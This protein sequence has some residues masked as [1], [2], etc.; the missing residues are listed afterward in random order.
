MKR[1]NEAK[2]RRLVKES[3]MDEMAT[4]WKERGLAGPYKLK[5]GEMGDTLAALQ[6]YVTPEGELP[7][8]FIHFGGITEQDVTA[9]KKTFKGAVNTYI[10]KKVG[11]ARSVTAPNRQSKHGPQF[12]FGVNPRSAEKYNTPYGIYAYPLTPSIFR[13]LSDGTLPFAQNE[14]FILLFKT[15]DRVPLIYTSEDIPED[16]Y[17]EYVQRLFSDEMVESER[18]V[19][20]T[21]GH[22]WEKKRRQHFGDLGGADPRPYDPP[23]DFLLKGKRELQAAYE[24]EEDPYPADLAFVRQSEHDTNQYLTDAMRE[25]LPFSASDSHSAH[26][27]GLVRSAAQEDPVRWSAMM[28]KLGIGGIVDDAGTGHIHSQEPVQ[29]VFFT[30]RDPEKNLEL[31]GVFPNTHTKRKIERRSLVEKTREIRE[32]VKMLVKEIHP[33]PRQRVDRE[34]I[35]NLISFIGLRD[36]SWIL[37]PHVDT[38]DMRE[39]LIDLREEGGPIIVE[40]YVQNYTGGSKIELTNSWVEWGRRMYD[41]G[42]GSDAIDSHPG[43][44]EH[45]AMVHKLR[46]LDNFSLSSADEKRAQEDFAYA[47]N[48]LAKKFKEI[49]DVV[50]KHQEMLDNYLQEA[51]SQVPPEIPAAWEAERNKSTEDIIASSLAA[52]SEE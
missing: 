42:Y 26:L 17:K 39:A 49:D 19:R 41:K 48:L 5:S 28:R 35:D 10:D 23:L 30:K 1:H 25:R 21:R 45:Y 4:A 24:K 40:F 22:K 31:I 3:R 13:S 6:Q 52:A 27:W 15:T 8:H 11:P 16:E 36:P 38:S 20:Y 18:N 32:L 12:K 2:W 47:R 46:S 9:V 33:N 51:P 34:I 50:V 44:K 37:D 14:P 7:T 29:A 43:A